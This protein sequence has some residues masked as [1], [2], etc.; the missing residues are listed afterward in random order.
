MK[1]KLGYILKIIRKMLGGATSQKSQKDIEYQIYLHYY[2][3]SGNALGVKRSSMIQLSSPYRFGPLFSSQN[4]I[5]SENIPKSS[6]F[7]M[8]FDD[9]CSFFQCYSILAE[10]QR[11]KQM[12]YSSLS[13]SASLD[14]QDTLQGAI[15][16]E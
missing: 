6:D 14:T 1:G 13:L 15:I 11:T 2:C 5:N 4:W 8:N 12:N 7:F 9:F 16:V 3:S 10:K